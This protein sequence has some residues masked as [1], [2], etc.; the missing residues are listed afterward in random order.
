[1]TSPEILNKALE[2]MAPGMIRQISANIE[3][4]RKDKEMTKPCG[5]GLTC[6]L[7]NPSKSSTAHLM[8]SII[9]KP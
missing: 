9:A 7:P 4:A 2:T 3:N 5:H 8:A 1:M 6:H